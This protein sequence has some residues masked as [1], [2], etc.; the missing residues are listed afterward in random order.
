MFV[1]D[2]S[3]G[4][5]YLSFGH[6]PQSKA[7]HADL[8]AAVRPKFAEADLVVGNLEAPITH[9][10]VHDQDYECSVLKVA[11]EKAAMLANAGFKVMQVAN[12]HTVQHSDAGFK[13]TLNHLRSLGIASIGCHGQSLHIV[14]SDCVSVGFLA[15]SEIP[16]NTDEKQTSYQRLDEEFLRNVEQSVSMCDHVVVMLHWGLEESISPLPRQR[17]LAQ[18]LK[19]MGVSAV[20][21]SHPHLFY[22]IEATAGFV[23]AY[24]LGNF[25][26][27]LCWDQ[28][29]L[30]SGI[31]D[32]EFGDGT[33][34]GRVWPVQLT[35]NGSIPIISSDP[36]PLEGRVKLYDLGK[37]MQ[38]QQIKKLLYFFRHIFMGD[39]RMK[40]RF[41]G[42]K[43]R[44]A[45]SG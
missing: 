44:R 31:L 8:F 43:L 25:V 18:K 12:N 24:S 32:L 37:N 42:S 28:R 11:P 23:S 7:D 27:D 26:F 30:K 21:G 38:N 16:D 1:G 20:V 40:I 15:A 5:Y 3:L 13:D 41:L 17:E 4:E 22:E 39:T 6:G 33:V 45:F 9:L 35:Q 29:L 2:V 10:N 14:E 34:D 19:D 36:V